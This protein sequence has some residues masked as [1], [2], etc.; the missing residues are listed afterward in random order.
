MDQSKVDHF[1]QFLKLS[2]LAP[3]TFE[4]NQATPPDGII[5]YGVTM[6]WMKKTKDHWESKYDRKKREERINDIPQYTTDIE[7]HSFVGLR[8]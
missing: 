4:N 5:H 6:D 8:Q 7:H 1:Y 3:L 2:A